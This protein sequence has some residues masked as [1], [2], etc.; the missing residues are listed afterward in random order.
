MTNRSKYYVLSLL[1]FIGIASFIIGACKKTRTDISNT[2]NDPIRAMDL[3][4]TPLMESYAVSFSDNYKTMPLL[5]ICKNHGINTIRIRL[6]HTPINNNSSLTEVLNF[7]KQC[8]SAGFKLYLDV[9]YSDS[10]ADP[11]KQT[12]PNAWKVCTRLSLMDSV[13]QYTED[14]LLQFKSQNCLPDYIQI[15]N[16]VNQGMLWNFGKVTSV[17]DT[18]WNYFKA[19]QL[20]AFN[21]IKTTSPATK[22]I[23]HY[24]GLQGAYDFFSKAQQMQLPFDL[25]GISYYPWWHGN[26][27]S[28]KSTITLLNQ[29]SKPII[30]AETA[31][32][33]TLNWNDWTINIVGT[34]NQLLQGFPASPIGQSNF[35]D[36]L[37]KIITPSNPNQVFGI[38]YWAPEYVA[39]KGT[40]D[41][42][43][44]PWENL[45]LFDF[46]HNACIGIKALGGK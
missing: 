26:L 30:I 3:S 40:Q 35:I 1:F 2:I 23:L 32:P 44:S 28:L 38:C 31:Y 4:F 41:T 22:I 46:Q 39:Y 45:C 18:N 17:N 27:T 36:S 10:W 14:V 34:S 24:A 6:W 21:K 37:W 29:L 13:S 15:G 43:A 16:E 33:F 7:A 25:V 11:G 12:I 9:H 5:Q 19:L 42:S 8:K 20:A